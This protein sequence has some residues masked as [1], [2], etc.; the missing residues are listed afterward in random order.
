[1]VFCCFGC[2]AHGICC[3]EHLKGFAAGNGELTRYNFYWNPD[4][5]DAA[6]TSTLCIMGQNYA[7]DLGNGWF[8]GFNMGTLLS[9]KYLE[10]QGLWII[11]VRLLKPKRIPDELL[12]PRGSYGPAIGMYDPDEVP[13]V[14]WYRGRR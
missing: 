3:S 8:F 9:H 4:N 1:M 12:Q 10:G 11:F 5:F 7:Y 6:R 14:F 2:R 13:P